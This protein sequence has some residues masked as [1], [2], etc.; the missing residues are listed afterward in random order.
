L[1]AIRKLMDEALSGAG[2]AEL[3]AGLLAAERALVAGAKKAILLAAGAA[4]QKYLQAVADQ[5]EI[6]GALADMILE[7]YAM[8]SAVARARKLVENQG[9]SAAAPACALA[10]LHLAGAAERVE[11]RARKV[12]AAVAEGDALRA[13]MLM[14]R[15][16]FRQEPAN[17]VALQQHVAQKLI[18][19][20]KY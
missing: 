12:L 11:L 15:R 10:R 1:P 4:S 8:D 6:M 5:Q 17:T 18:E 20:G 2:A 3:P 13:H 16:W 7:V 9:E 14:L 19:A